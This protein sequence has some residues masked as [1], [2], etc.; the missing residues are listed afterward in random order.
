MRAGG[1]GEAHVLIADA[2]PALRAIVERV[3]R[4]AG[5]RASHAGTAAEALAALRSEPDLVVADLALGDPPG[6]GWIDALRARGPSAEIVVTLR[7]ASVDEAVAC[8]RAGAF[9]VLEKPF[10]DV[11]RL[12]R[13][14]LRARERHRLRD[15][16]GARAARVGAGD[17]PFGI[18]FRSGA[19]QRVLRTVLDLRANESHV[20][21]EAESG[22]GKELVARAIHATS[23]RRDGPFVP[24]DCGALA[25]GIAEGE[26]FGYER[27]AFTGAV[28]AS[29]GLFR[30]AAG[31]TLFLDE[32]AELPLHL[33]AKL[34]RAL[35]E[36]EVRPLGTGAP[37]WVDVRIIAATHRDLAERVREGRFRADLFF[38]LRVVLLT[39]PPL[40]ERPEDIPPLALHFLGRLREGA[41]IRGIEPEAMEALA[42]RP[43]EGNVRELENTIEAAVA[44][45]PGPE[46]R[47]ADLGLREPPEAAPCA[48]RPAGIEL[49]LASYERACLEEAL[50]RAQ[51]DVQRAARL[52]GIG[53]STLYR[54][55]GQHRLLRSPQ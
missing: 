10:R 30:T 52:L 12:E 36:R 34:L 14:L 37:Q 50:A 22:T 5:L 3:A 19:M 25:E 43:W 44:L 49:S 33:Q 40:R 47:L 55:L 48:P 13:T 15:E 35:Q 1:R 53:R 6:V 18:V 9:D 41:R 26:L 7:Y 54:K 31:G 38:R 21:I 17:A 27:G 51:G 42:A 8:M 16:R 46:L 4:S 39:V 32:I 2:D 29:P 45:A 11:A 23:P 20:L 24:V 28:R